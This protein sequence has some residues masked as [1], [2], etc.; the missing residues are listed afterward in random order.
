[1]RGVHENYTIASVI[2]SYSDRYVMYGHNIEGL[3]CAE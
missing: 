1:M 3:N 2:K